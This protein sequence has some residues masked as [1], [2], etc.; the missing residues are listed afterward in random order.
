MKSHQLFYF[1]II[2]VKIQ[3]SS[4]CLYAFVDFF[5]NQ[6]HIVFLLNL[7]FVNFLHIIN[8][9]FD[10][11]WDSQSKCHSFVVMSSCPTNSMQIDIDINIVISVWLLGWAYIYY[12]CSIS[13]INSSGHNISAH[14]DVCFWMFKFLYD[15]LF[16]VMGQINFFTIFVGLRRNSS[17]GQILQILRFGTREIGCHRFKDLVELVDII[18]R[19]K[20]KEHLRFFIWFTF[21][22]ELFKNNF[23]YIVEYLYFWILCTLYNVSIIFNTF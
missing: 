9:V 11:L 6:F 21:T 19:I 3:Q 2:Y 23:Q 8:K 5:R 15:L 7:N 14:Q 1:S 12:E 16:F 18:N 17:S 10:F 20:K 4:I 13:N 22:I